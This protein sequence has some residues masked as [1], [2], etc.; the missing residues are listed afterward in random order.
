MARKNQIIEALKIGPKSSEELPYK[1][2]LS[3]MSA[4]NAALCN[5]LTVVGRRSKVV[6][7][8]GQFKTVYYLT[9]DINRAV[10]KFVDLNYDVLARI[11][12]DRTQGLHAGLP[13]GVGKL[14]INRFRYITEDL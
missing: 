3:H 1:F 2:L 8:F 11:N 10:E 12:L 13:K 4:E 9:G 14:V 5:K 6:K 7:G